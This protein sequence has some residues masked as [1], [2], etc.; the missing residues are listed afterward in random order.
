MQTYLKTYN[1]Y[2]FNRQKAFKAIYIAKN[3][4]L[5]KNIKK[6]NKINMEYKDN[7]LPKG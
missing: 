3:S 1:L 6:H 7:V 2:N 4:R 5:N